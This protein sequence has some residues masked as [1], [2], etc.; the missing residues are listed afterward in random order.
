MP[1]FD[2]NCSMLFAEQ[3]FLDR[4]ER[5]ARAGF[6]AV[7]FLFPYA[8]APS[9]IG[10]RLEA[11]GLAAILFNTPPGDWDAGERGMACIPGREE[12]FRAGVMRALE[13]ASALGVGNVHVL[14]GMAPAGVAPAQVRRTY[15][16]NL[17]FAATQF[18]AAGAR[19]LIE[20]INGFDMPGYYLCRTAQ[21]L[22][23]I[24]EVAAPNLLLQYDLYH[25]QRSEGELAATIETHLA[26]IGHMQIADNPGRHEPGSGEIN[27][28]FLFAH[29]DRI[30]YAGHIG[31]EYRPLGATEAGLDWFRDATR[32]ARRP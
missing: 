5:A 11:N 28:A 8:H 24:D 22:S 29:V 2:A 12:E 16:D 19:A 17:R 30:G 27:F 13:Y 7:E 10:Q 20:P 32:H 26:K 4:F 15:V 23:V 21:A 14:A 3:P 31:C 25:A 6:D 1:R 18:A 9:E